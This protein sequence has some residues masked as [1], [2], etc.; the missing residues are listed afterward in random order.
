MKTNEWIQMNRSATT[1]I[2][3]N[4]HDYKGLQLNT[5]YTNENKRTQTNTNA[6][7]GIQMS[8]HEFDWIRMKSNA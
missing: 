4:E 2:H 8:A 3:M 6:Y 5:I 7:N 1:W